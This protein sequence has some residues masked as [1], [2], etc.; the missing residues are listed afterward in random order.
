MKQKKE[1]IKKE[2]FLTG[3]KAELSRINWPGRKDLRKQFLVVL[4]I[5]V[6]AALLIACAD[7][8]I[9]TGIELL[10]SRI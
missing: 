10:I 1:K 4:L 7:T 3:V 2:Y 6:A 8:L 5:G 9:Q